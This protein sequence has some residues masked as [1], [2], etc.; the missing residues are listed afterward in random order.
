MPAYLGGFFLA[1]LLGAVF[2]S[3][4][5]LLNSAATMFCLDVY[6]PMRKRALGDGE[7]VTVAKYASIAIAL[8]SFM[9]APLL[10]FAPEGLWQIIRI[11]T[12]LYNIPVVVIV[13]VGL[14]TTRVPAI[15]AKIVIIFHVIA[16][17]L[18]KF[19]LDDVITMHFL[20]LY[21]VLAVIEIAIMLIAGR[22]SPRA[23]PWSYAD[24]KIVD[25]TPWR[26]AYPV[27]FSLLSAVVFLYLLF[28]PVGLV[29]GV[30]SLFWLLTGALL[31]ANV[32][33]W[34]IRLKPS[35]AAA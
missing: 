22:L 18:A 20:H 14:F 26:Y 1:V 12:G 24:Q 4:N 23:T 8:F 27:A 2:S 13:L 11:F 30:T 25:L 21:A 17:G 29:D 7:L 6:A 10:Q 31:L 32:G 19:V 15:G 34:F 35:P 33:Y 9:V 5:S 28:S 3:F 16:Y